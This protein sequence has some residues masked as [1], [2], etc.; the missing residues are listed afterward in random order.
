MMQNLEK[1]IEDIV[2]KEDHSDF[3][4]DLLLAYGISKTTI[5]KAKKDVADL[6]GNRNQIILKKKVFFEHVDMG[7]G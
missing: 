2:N 6:F 7:I 5:T 3:I 1:V 4:Y